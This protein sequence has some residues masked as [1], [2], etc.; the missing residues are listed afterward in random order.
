M[1]GIVLPQF[2][3]PPSHAGGQDIGQALWN[4]LKAIG[5][6]NKNSAAAGVLGSLA[7]Q[8]KSPMNVAAMLVPGGAGDMMGGSPLQGRSWLEA[9]NMPKA[10][11]SGNVTFREGQPWDVHNDITMVNRKGGQ[12]LGNPNDPAFRQ[13]LYRQLHDALFGGTVHMTPGHNIPPRP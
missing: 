7:N 4:V 8:A 9:Y 1:P 12:S 5:T 11:S 10:V 13:E 2:A 6:P 3:P